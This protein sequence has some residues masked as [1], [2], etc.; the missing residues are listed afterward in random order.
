MTTPHTGNGGGDARRQ[1]PDAD[2]RC[3]V[4]T[5]EHGLC[6]ASSCAGPIVAVALPSPARLRVA[7]LAVKPSRSLSRL[8]ELLEESAVAAGLPAETRPFRPHVSIA[9][10]RGRR[11]RPPRLP[12]DLPAADLGA[13]AREVILFRSD[14]G[15][16]GP[17]YTPVLRAALGTGALSRAGEDE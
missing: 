6:G 7:A 17:V 13:E 12:G 8:A 1:P 10:T 4:G 14:R 9:R 2:R 5:G 16:A 3:T 15:E 11:R